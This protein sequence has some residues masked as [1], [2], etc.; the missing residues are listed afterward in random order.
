[1][2][3]SL[4]HRGQT[5]VLFCLTL[6]LLTLMVCMTLSIGMKAKEKM[7]L[8]TAADAAAYSQAVATAR[9]YNSISVLSRAFV[10]NMVAMAGVNSLISW[11]AMYRASVYRAKQDYN[12]PKTQYEVIALA[13]CACPGPTCNPP[14][15]AC[16]NKAI[17]DITQTQN[18]LD[19]EEQ[20]IKGIWDGLDQPAGDEEKN[21]QISSVSTRQKELFRRL[22]DHEIGGEHNIGKAI[23]DELNKGNMYASDE[24]S[25]VDAQDNVNSKE[26]EGGQCNGSKPGAACERRDAGHKLHFIYATMGT[27]GHG[28]VTGRSGGAGLIQMQLMTIIQPPDIV[29]AQDTGSG[30]FA[31]SDSPSHGV[32]GQT[33]NKHAW[34]EDHGSVFVAFLRQ[35]GP[36]PPGIPMTGNAEA[37]VRSND[38]TGAA[39]TDEHSWTGGQDSSADPRHTMGS[40]TLCP[41]MWPSHMDYNWDQVDK[42]KNNFG[43]PKTYAVL[44]RDL[45]KRFTP[46]A[47]PW[48]LMFNFK[49]LSS[50]SGKKFDNRGL[51]LT[52]QGNADIS[53]ATA[54]SA[55]IAYYHRRNDGTY[56]EPPNFLNPFWRATLT[57]AN[58]DL[59]DGDISDISSTLGASNLSQAKDVAEALNNAG[60]RAW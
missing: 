1:M 32:K 22:M 10:S 44:E 20:R 23:A 2:K 8:K 15:C 53:H 9:T 47:D 49:F 57:R 52:S 19:Q 39:G 28:F 48:N 41:G 30:N 43:Q 13:A 55:G 27:R 35:T 18:K 34:G 24:V 14:M 5:L 11:A 37:H 54:L 36:C 25:V 46:K 58:I 40:C 3:I 16:A 21:L 29:T 31:D 26:Q 60:Y 12:T 4:R 45:S 42:E 51:K 33:G 17:G 38:S 59:Q 56:R 7:E 6:L 50:G